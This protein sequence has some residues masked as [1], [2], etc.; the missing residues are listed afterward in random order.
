M[1]SLLQVGLILLLGMLG[2]VALI[3]SFKRQIE[4]IRF[5]PLLVKLIKVADRVTYLC[6]YLSSAKNMLGWIVGRGNLPWT[7]TFLLGMPRMQGTDYS[8]PKTFLKAVC[9]QQAT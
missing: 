6:K 7:S 2:I 9:L 1:R 8:L 3:K 4:Q 5:L